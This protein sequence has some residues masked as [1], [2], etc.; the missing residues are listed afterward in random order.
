METIRLMTWVDAPVERCFK[1]SLSVDLRTAASA[2]EKAVD[3]VRTG[4]LGEGEMVAWSGRP[5]GL[6][7]RRTSRIDVWRPHSYFREVMVDGIFQ[8]FEHEHFFAV[9]DDGTRMRDEVRFTMPG[10]PL[11]RVAT[12]LFVRRRMTALLLRRNATIKRA[13]ESE[14]WHHYL[15]GRTGVVRETAPQKGLPIGPWDRNA[16]LRP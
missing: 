13:A 5:F 12:R 8:R 7:L 10:G 2:G 15:D 6:N 1:L 4:L 11:G 16:I 3:E 9:M 14:E